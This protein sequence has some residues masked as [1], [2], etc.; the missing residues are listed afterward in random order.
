MNCIRVEFSELLLDE[1]EGLKFLNL[2]PEMG[3][4]ELFRFIY[5][6]DFFARART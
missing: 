2:L 4:I 6:W 1:S 3:H 5:I